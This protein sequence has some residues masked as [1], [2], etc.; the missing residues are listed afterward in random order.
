MKIGILLTNTGTP[1]APTPK[2]VREYLAEFLADKRIVHLPRLIWLPILYGLVLPLRAKHSAKLYQA[3]WT[4]NGSPMLVKMQAVA[5]ALKR[6]LQTRG[7]IEVT[8]GMHY[9]EPSIAHGLDMLRQQ[10]VD[11]VIVLPLFP[12][13][14]N[15]T[16]ASTYDRVIKALSKWNHLPHVNFISNYAEDDHYIQ[17]VAQSIRETWYSQGAANH[18]LIS[19]HGLPERFVRDGDP[20]QLQCEATAARIAEQLGLP[21]DKWT[22]CYQSQFGYDKWLKPSTQTL[23]SELPKRG[24]KRVDVVCPGFSVDCLET[25]EEIS[26]QGK[27]LFVEAGGGALRYIPALNESS[28]QIEML[29]HLVK[30]YL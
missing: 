16:T 11:K 9:G 13:Y 3:I 23:L 2:A 14:S 12:Q 1:A 15:A 10:N 26:Q 7:D 8:V 24:I 25:L 5:G 17:A 6:R 22:L 27:T 21:N 20:Y 4:T 30:K 18:L 19:F 28:A 29:S